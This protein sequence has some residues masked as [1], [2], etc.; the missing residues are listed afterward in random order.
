[1]VISLRGVDD[2]LWFQWWGPHRSIQDR[3]RAWKSRPCRA[4][5]RVFRFVGERVERGADA[6]LDG[7]AA[8]VGVERTVARHLELQRLVFGAQDCA[9]NQGISRH[10]GR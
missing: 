6:R 3:R 5:A 1:M 4:I 9:S 8:G 2:A 7:R 10:C